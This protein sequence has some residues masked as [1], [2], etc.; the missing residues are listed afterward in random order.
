MLSPVILSSVK[1][2]PYAKPVFRVSNFRVWLRFS[3]ANGKFESNCR[4]IK[5]S[6]IS[7][8]QNTD[9][10]IRIYIYIYSSDRFAFTLEG[11]TNIADR[12]GAWTN[13][14]QRRSCWVLVSKYT[15]HSQTALIDLS[16][17]LH[18][19]DG[20]VYFVVLRNQ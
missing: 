12:T 2:N 5:A 8:G 1:E 9:R 14:N 11:G 18:A 7:S 3:G 10:Y 16:I 4:T 19:R 15:S 13:H 20:G 17:L 6:T